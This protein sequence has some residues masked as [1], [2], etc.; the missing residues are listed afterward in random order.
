MT[1]TAAMTV[2]SQAFKD[3]MRRLAA[4]V[5]ILTVGFE[6]GRRYG[7]T[8]TAV[9]SVSA[10]PPILLCCINRKS[11]AHPYFLEATRFGVNILAAEHQELA[12]RF[13]SSCPP[14]E[15]FAAGEWL[16]TDGGVPL[17]NTATANF[18]CAKKDAI[19][20]GEHTVFF[21]EVIGVSTRPEEVPCLV[22]GHGNF[23]EFR[24][25]ERLLQKLPASPTAD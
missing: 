9:C 14:H 22:Y 18:V 25:R 8:A 6:D 23:G 7:M 2:D 12:K 16:T 21:G 15:R 17:L 1:K 11:G 19:E 5:T 10:E 3:G 4:S 13:A 20:M 24:P